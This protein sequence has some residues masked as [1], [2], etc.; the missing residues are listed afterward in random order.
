MAAKRSLDVNLNVMVMQTEQ[1]KHSWYLQYTQNQSLMPNE[2]IL[3]GK[4]K[5]TRRD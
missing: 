4:N 5:P 3:I 1:V 2:C